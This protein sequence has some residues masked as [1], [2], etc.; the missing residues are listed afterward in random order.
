MRELTNSRIKPQALLSTDKQAL[1]PDQ[2]AGKTLDMN[3]THKCSTVSMCKASQEL[4]PL[5]TNLT[6]L[7][8]SKR[9][10]HLDLLSI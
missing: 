6:V 2:V 1:Q 3:V 4:T 5:T 8:V 9:N 7:H 10:R